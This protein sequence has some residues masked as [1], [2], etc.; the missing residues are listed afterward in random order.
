MFSQELFLYKEKHPTRK[1]QLT[2]ALEWQ[3][4]QTQFS[5]PTGLEYRR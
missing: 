1:P 3:E 5:I 4:L 2:Q